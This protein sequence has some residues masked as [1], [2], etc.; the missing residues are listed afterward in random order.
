VHYRNCRALAVF[1]VIVSAAG[2]CREDPI[3]TAPSDLEG[4]VKVSDVFFS[5][6]SVALHRDFMPV[7]LNPG[8]DGGR[9]LAGSVL[10]RIVNDGGDDRFAVRA[11]VFD[12][13]GKGS[14]VDAVPHEH[15][16][17]LVWDGSIEAGGT[18]VIEVRLSGGPYLPPK[19]R[20]S[21]RLE[22]IAKDGDRGSVVTPPAEVVATY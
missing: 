11:T 22:W 7:V 18:R 17:F 19:T 21:I 14:P 1:I 4:R 8:P 2:G 9:P 10:V 5:V 3:P 6:A 13:E 20:A 15:A 16:K 12:A